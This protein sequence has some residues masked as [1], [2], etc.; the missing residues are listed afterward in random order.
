MAVVQGPN[1]RLS[2]I[3]LRLLARPRTF[4][5]ALCCRRCPWSHRLRPKQLYHTR[6]V[7]VTLA[8]VRVSTVWPLLPNFTS[9]VGWVKKLSHCSYAANSAHANLFGDF[10]ISYM[11]VKSFYDISKDKEIKRVTFKCVFLIM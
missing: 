4:H 3:S 1:G 11:G 7:A 2:R 6:S 9:V 8:P 10:E 5:F